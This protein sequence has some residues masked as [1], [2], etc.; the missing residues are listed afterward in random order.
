MNKIRKV[1]SVIIYDKEYDVY[2]IDG[3]EHG[4]Y[5]GEIK[6]WWVYFSQKVPDGTVPPLDS[7]HWQPLVSSIERHTWE[8]TFKQKT[9]TKEKWGNTNFHNHTW[10]EM[11]CNKK[12]IYAFRATG[13]SR[14]MSFAMAKAQYM[15]TY[16]AEHPYNFFNAEEENG[17]KI[18]WYGLP[19]TVKVMHDTWEIA[20]IPD[21]TA[22]ISE[23]DWWEELAKKKHKHTIPDKEWDEIEKEDDEETR[24]AG[25]INWGDAFSDGHIDWFRKTEEENNK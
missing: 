17:R 25:Y 5:N 3:K 21:Y 24:S 2:N 14:G 13:G 10:C 8:I 4:G 20:I 11:W 6:T 18:C 16:L 9:T 15:Q 12:L 19:A 22:G 7:E 23:K 1:F